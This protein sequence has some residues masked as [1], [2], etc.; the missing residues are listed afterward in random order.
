MATKLIVE[1]GHKLTGVVRVSGSKNAALPILASTLLTAEP[2]VIH[3]MPDIKDIRVLGE[4]IESMG[5]K[6]EWLGE[7]IV[8]VDNSGI[9]GEK[10][11]DYKKIKQL[12]AS[13]MIM[14]PLLTRFGQV[15]MS[16]PGGCHIGPRPIDVHLDGMEALGAKITN[17]GEYYILNANRLQGTKV[18]LD[19]MSVTGT[20][21]VLMAAVMAG[22]TTEIRL[23]A[24]EPEN[25]NLVACL[26]K[27]GAK[28]SGAGTHTLIINGVDKLHGGEVEVI[29]DRLEAGTFAVMAAVT[30]GE[31]TIQGY[32]WDHLDLVTNKLKEAGVRIEKVDAN[33]AK[34]LK[35]VSLKPVEI[36]TTVYPG[37]P[38]DLQAPFGTLLTQAAGTS[39]I[40]ETMYD[41]R[42]NYFK[43]LAKM[44]ATADILDPHRAVV[45]GPT[46]LYGKEIDSLDIRAGATLVVAALAAHGKSII[47]QAE[48]IDRGYERMD[49]KLRGLG[50]K[51]ERVEVEEPIAV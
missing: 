38:T 49:E 5:G 9:D 37:F 20:S 16:M 44:G 3:N 24:A 51:I 48:L 29:P 50:A 40:H 30:Q 18:V 39:K 6:V 10:E 2:V 19:E 7:G 14:G 45:S 17:D 43:E 13:I 22:G 4:I 47:N 1:G 15:R 8:R 46:V 33:T 34:I 31:V 36:K 27:M 21:N 25:N 32:V 26:I 42:L 28:I 12:R 23:A 41:G 35:T 11:P